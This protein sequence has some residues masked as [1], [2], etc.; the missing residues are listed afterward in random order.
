MTAIATIE[1]I[2][3]AYAAKLAEAGV[4][5]TNRLIKVA[6]SKAGRKQLAEDT[7]LSEGQILEWLNR[8]DLM[9]VRGVGEE[10][11]DLLERAGVDS[12]TELAQ[13]N[14]DNLYEALIAETKK[15]N[16]VRRPPS[17]SEVRRWKEHAATLEKVV[18]H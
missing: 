5:T 7:G 2:G 12:P 17:L 13:R 3:P 15:G 1:G 4:K 10:Y 14:P 11:S 18:T 16:V 6:G 9:R 8:A